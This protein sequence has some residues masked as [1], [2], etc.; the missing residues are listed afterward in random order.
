MLALKTYHLE[1]I[2]K[3]MCRS[4]KKSLS[5][6]M[7]HKETPKKWLARSVIYARD[8]LTDFSLKNTAKRKKKKPLNIL[9]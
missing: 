1:K 6:A 4:E 9:F 3:M 7:C 2:C 8:M 5:F